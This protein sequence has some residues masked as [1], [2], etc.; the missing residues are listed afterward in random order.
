MLYLLI[1]ILCSTLIFAIFKGFDLVKVHT[2]YAIIVNYLIAFC[3]GLVLY[4]A[5]PS[6]SV[7]YETSWFWG[8]VALGVFFILIF[9]LMAKTSQVAGVSVASVATKM[10]LAIPVLIGVI[11]YKESLS[12]L[13]VLGIL[14]AL[15][16]VY[17]ASVKDDMTQGI[18]KSLLLPAMVF[19]GSGI[20]D[21]SM[22]YFEEFHLTSNEVPLFSAL[23]FG[24]AALTGLLFIGFT[25]SKRPK[26][27][28]KD[29]V[30]GIVLGIPNY[31]SIYFLIRALENKAFGSASIFTMNNVGIVVC[32]TLLG[33][34]F[35][36]ERLSQKNWLGIGIAISSIVL[37]ALF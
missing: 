22:K 2:L 12:G 7:V 37:V 23:I 26:F 32:S 20:I 18:G 27:Q 11:W 3:T 24:F 13:Q 31:F 25:F 6:V 5:F 4:G 29:L 30:G 16:S 21:S 28:I 14:L 35:F 34:L 33:I 1:S 8:T 10:S 36:K 15:L 17:L 9:N 19:L